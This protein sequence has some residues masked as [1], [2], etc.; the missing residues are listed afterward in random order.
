MAENTLLNEKNFCVIDPN[1]KSFGEATNL[2]ALETKE[3]I[4]H[5]QLSFDLNEIQALCQLSQVTSEVKHTA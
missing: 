4:Q 2:A 5:S 3:Q 1:S